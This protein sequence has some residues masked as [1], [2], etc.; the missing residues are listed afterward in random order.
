MTGVALEI[1]EFSE[2]ST[3]EW[4]D[5]VARHPLGTPFHL[6]AWRRTIADSFGYRPIY[7]MASSEGRLRGI[8]P[9]FLVQ[10]WMVGKV[11]VSTPFAVYGGIL[12][13]S[14]EVLRELH[15]HAVRLGE[16][17][18]VD[19][20]ELRNR[21]REQCANEPNV[22]RYVSFDQ[23]PVSDEAALLEALPKKT[24]NV[25]RKSLKQGF[26]MRYGVTDLK[27][28][29]DLYTKNLRRL[30]TPAFPSHYF[31][32][33]MRYFG[34]MTAVREVWLDTKPVAVSLNFLFRG[35]M[36][37]YYAA[38]DFNYNALAPNTFMYFDHLRW[39]GTNGFHL[40]DFGRSKRG[41]G[42]F[43]FKR[44]WNTTMHEL[45]YEI[46]L[47]RRKELPN[48]S[49]ANPKFDAAIRLWRLLPLWA[50]RL[51]GPRL[52]RLFP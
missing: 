20:I 52:I 29:E 11:L 50:T 12:A 18:G 39:A 47:I 45:P 36:H 49:P 40:F 15:A 44:H 31:Q 21:H 30:G 22:D 26:Q 5:F 4:D 34:D 3:A 23:A 13:D 10:N 1:Q 42:V 48:F 16:Q 35:E 8:L 6:T 9:M 24:R 37:T 25:A 14:E 7:L 46:V 19:Y 38:T 28:F 51:I 41:T 32:N 33:L 43:E 27:I 17:L 2:S